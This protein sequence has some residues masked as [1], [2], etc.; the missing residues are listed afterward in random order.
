MTGAQVRAVRERLGL[1]Q[2]QA[3]R[4]WRLSQAYV[5]LVEHG[6]RPAP[7]RLAA[8]LARTEP[9]MATGLPLEAAVP[10]A[11]DLTRRLGA[12]GY[13]EF[14]YLADP[15]DL[16][17]PAAVVLATLKM[18]VVPARVTEALPWLLVT[19][20]D[21]DWGWLMDQAKLA[22]VQNRL[23]YLLG[24]AGSSPSG[25]ASRPLFSSSRRLNEGWKRP[26]SRRRIRS[27][28]H[29]PRLSAATCDNTGRRR[30]HTGIC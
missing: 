11:E 2:Q 6:K 7:D 3:A 26:V 15:R 16:A 28:A 22:N 4:R 20:A 10:A 17:N 18:P 9:R 19:F 21:L 23:G 5:S 13:P 12:L 25:E 8:L 14:T 30:P 1:T 29:S 24:L 27:A